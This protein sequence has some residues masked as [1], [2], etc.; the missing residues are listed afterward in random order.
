MVVGK[1]GT[2]NSDRIKEFCNIIRNSRT[3]FLTGSGTSYHCA[4][5][6]KHL[7]SNF[8]KIHAETMVSSEFQYT[9][10]GIDN[11]S[12]LLAISQSGET[13]DVLQAVKAAK[14]YGS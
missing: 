4:L 3:V 10:D 8:A 5:I 11:T 14:A 2:Q 12:V 13:A 9:L 1:V 7:L 6:A